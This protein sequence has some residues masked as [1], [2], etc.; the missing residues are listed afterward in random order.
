MVKGAA[1]RERGGETGRREAEGVLESDRE[2]WKV[3]EM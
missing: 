3:I 1:E 2:G